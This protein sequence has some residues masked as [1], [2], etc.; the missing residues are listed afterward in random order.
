MPPYACGQCGATVEAIE[1]LAPASTGLA[2]PQA[3]LLAAAVRGDH[4]L[5]LVEVHAASPDAK[6]RR[7]LLNLNANGDDTC[8]FTVLGLASS[9]DGRWLASWFDRTPPPV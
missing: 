4:R 9:P 3:P 2:L 6:L 1:W 8:S 5:H 7:R